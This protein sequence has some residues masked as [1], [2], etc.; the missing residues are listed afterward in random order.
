[1]L[2]EINGNHKVA[3]TEI[4]NESADV[5]DLTIPITHNFALSAGIF[6]HNSI[7]GDA[8]A[9][10]RYTECR[11]AKLAEEMLEN[12]DKRTVKFVPNFDSSTTEPLVL[13]SKYPNLLVNG[14]SG[15]A[16]GMA[17]NIP[18]H[19]MAEV[20]NAVIAQIG[21][22]D[23]S[24]NELMQHIQGPDFPTGG[25]ICG[26]NGIMEAYSKGR[27]KLIVRAKTSFEETKTK[28]SII[29]TE[30]PYMVNKSE[31]IEEIADN[32][33]DKR[34]IGIS[35]IRDESDRDGMRIVIELRKDADRDVVLNQLFEHSRLQTTF[36]IIMLALVDNVPKVAQEGCYK[37]KDALRP[38]Q[39]ADK[40]PYT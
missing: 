32:V 27:G 24:L 18:P 1:M 22:H 2:C 33:R 3:K 26:K 7:D 37:G 20:I 8:P 15:I 12:I 5:Y 21:N 19:N 30:I 29:V 16:V 4:L 17:T 31:M 14:S 28:E 9:A 35:D 6:V 38:Q 40:C 25:I 36:G 11:L 39:G 23:I 34:I 10:M 13:P